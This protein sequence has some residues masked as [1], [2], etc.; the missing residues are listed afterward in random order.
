MLHPD[1]HLA[2][3]ASVLGGPV[4]AHLRSLPF[5]TIT[6]GAVALVGLAL[7]PLGAG[8]PTTVSVIAFALGG[9]TWAPYLS[10][11]M[12]LH[13]RRSGRAVAARA[14]RE[15]R[16]GRAGGPARDRARRCSVDGWGARETLLC[17]SIALM[18]I[19]F[20][21]V[22]LLCLPRPD[23]RIHGRAPRFLPA[24]ARDPLP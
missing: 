24:T 2:G 18:P 19:A 9:L 22:V 14:R 16:G 12:A 11:T 17:S 3:I 8:A 10:T 4:T 5:W 13:Q 1:D 20:L 21:A 23:G 15:Q 7:L 6:V